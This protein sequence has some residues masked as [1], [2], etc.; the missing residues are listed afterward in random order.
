[1][2][3]SLVEIEPRPPLVG[4]HRIGFGA[5]AEN[6]VNIARTMQKQAIPWRLC[7]Q[8]LNSRFVLSDIIHYNEVNVNFAGNIR[9]V[10]VTYLHSAHDPVK[11]WL[12]TYLSQLRF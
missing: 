1:M 10:L 3:W 4:N 5:S 8:L 2:S 11:A 6:I 7:V 12:R 9:V